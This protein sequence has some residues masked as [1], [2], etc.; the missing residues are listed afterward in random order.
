MPYLRIGYDVLYSYLVSPIDRRL[1]RTLRHLRNNLVEPTAEAETRTGNS[2]NEDEDQRNRFILSDLLDLG[3]T[4]W[5]ILSADQESGPEIDLRI[6]V[7]GNIIENMSTPSRF[8]PNNGGLAEAM[9]QFQE[10]TV[11][12]PEPAQASPPPAVQEAEAQAPTP[13]PA[14]ALAAQLPQPAA[15]G[16][17]GLGVRDAVELCSFYF[18]DAINSV[19]TSLLFPFISYGMGEL[20][21]LSLPRSWTSLPKPIVTSGFFSKG[22][23]VSKAPTGLLQQRWGRSLVGGCLFVVIRDVFGVYAKYKKVQALKAR[24]IIR[25]RGGGDRAGGAGRRNVG[26]GASAGHM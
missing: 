22:T 21:R 5:I 4:A 15:Q 2:N 25:R 14:P 6:E 10:I 3:R 9:G 7:G 23:V 26:A 8:H 20:I 17:E 18:S 24:R 13:A 16:N 12:T 1:D 11:A 19:A